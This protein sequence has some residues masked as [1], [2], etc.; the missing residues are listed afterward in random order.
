M[1]NKIITYNPKL[2]EY[3]RDNDIPIK[4]FYI[5]IDEKEQI[6]NLNEKRYS[7]AEVKKYLSKR[8]NYS[9]STSCSIWEGM[10][11]KNLFLKLIDNGNE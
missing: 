7:W 5:N 2:K 6:K 3:A 4:T 10:W 11:D 1:K 9:P 8:N